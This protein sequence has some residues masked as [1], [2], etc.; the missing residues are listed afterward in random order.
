MRPSANC[1]TKLSNSAVLHSTPVSSARC[2]QASI[3][4]SCVSARPPTDTR[5]PLTQLNSIP[6]RLTIERRESSSYL[7]DAS[8]T[9]SATLLVLRFLRSKGR[10]VHSSWQAPTSTRRHTLRHCLRDTREQRRRQAPLGCAVLRQILSHRFRVGS[11]WHTAGHETDS[12]LAQRVLHSAVLAEL[13]LCEHVAREA[14]L[15]VDWHTD[16]GVLTHSLVQVAA[17]AL[18]QILSTSLLDWLSHLLA[19]LPLVGILWHMAVHS[20]SCCPRAF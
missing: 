2:T 20:P 7:A 17:V 5:N 3:A 16:A 4:L 18:R 6:T 1:L 15:H 13:H 11:V 12:A 9:H 19:Q 10:R 8:A 14:A